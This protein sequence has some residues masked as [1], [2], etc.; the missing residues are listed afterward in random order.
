MIFDG[1]SAGSASSQKFDLYPILYPEGST[2]SLSVISRDGG[3]V[4]HYARGMASLLILSDIW[5]DE[6]K[7]ASHS[8]VELTPMGAVC[9]GDSGQLTSVAF[10]AAQSVQAIRLHTLAQGSVT[11]EYS[12]DGGA[13]WHAIRDGRDAWFDVPQRSVQIRANLSGAG[14]ILQGLDVTGV[15]EMNP[16]RFKVQLLRPVTSFHLTG[17]SEFTEAMPAIETDCPAEL[18]TRRLYMDGAWNSNTFTANLLPCEDGSVH[19]VTAL[20]LDASGR[21]YGSGAKTSLLLR[22]APGAKGVYESGRL[23]LNGDAYAIRLETLCQDDSGKVVTSGL[24]AYSYDGKTWTDFE[25]NDYA[26]LPQAART[27]Y[28]RAMLPEGVTLR[29]LHLEGVT[30]AGKAISTSL[31]KAPANVQAA[32]YGDY[33]E[34]EKLRRYVITWSDA[35]RDDPSLANEIYFDIYRDGKRIATTRSTR[36][37]DYD[38]VS[39]AVY[40]VAARRVYDDPQDG[41]ASELT[42]D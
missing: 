15:Y 11:Y 38:Y 17:G 5:K 3:D 4:L 30:A 2:H 41:L 24:Y 1:Q 35:N 16:V 42:Y 6:S 37:E 20:G 12:I 21:L 29:A 39:G 34:N 22:T 36:Y 28:V 10:S 32:D 18:T 14:T 7:V 40:H 25:L 27:L 8:G 31:I 33:Y 26:F 23:T 19:T 9:A 13:S